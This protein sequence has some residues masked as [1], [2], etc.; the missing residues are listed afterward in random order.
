MKI[1]SWNVNGLRSVYQKGA[2]KIDQMGA[3]ILCLQEIKALKEQLDPE[4]VSPKGYY[5]YFNSAKKKGYAGTAV[6]SRQKP[7]SGEEKIGFKEF[8]EEGRFLKL[9]YPQFSLVNLYLPHGGR[10]KEKLAYKLAV[11]DYLLNY[12]QKFK[13]K[14]V[15]L[16]GDFNIAHEEID[17]A[18]PKENKNNIMFTPEERAIINRLVGSGFID[19]FRKFYPDKRGV[20]TWWP[21]FAN[22]RAR[23]LG[24]RIDYIFVTQKLAVKLK[25]AFILS[26]IKGSDHCPVGVEF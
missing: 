1:I 15:I 2:L 23:N 8:D 21:Y 19:S 6:Y 7:L 9:D 12:L 22:A 5:S 10:Q 4:L 24:W 13:E 25:N 26:Q 20:Y 3:D 11:Y 16:A 17:L 14:K 18:R